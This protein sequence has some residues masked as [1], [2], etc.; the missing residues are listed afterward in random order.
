MVLVSPPLHTSPDVVSGADPFV[1][2]AHMPTL[3]SGGVLIALQ[4]VA[5]ILDAAGEALPR[6]ESLWQLLQIGVCRYLLCYATVA[7]RPF[8]LASTLR[9]VH[10]LFVL[11]RHNLILQVRAAALAVSCRL[12]CPV[13]ICVPRI[14]TKLSAQIKAFFEDIFITFL[15][16][17][18]AIA[19][20]DRTPSDTSLG[21]STVTSAAHDSP[22][23]RSVMSL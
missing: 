10:A 17:V 18:T 20:G 19:T 9:V 5:E 11:H 23:P 1:L 22:K 3:K 2:A 21:T 7:T 12:P 16:S 14:K 13:L 15:D 8:L 4:L 6:H